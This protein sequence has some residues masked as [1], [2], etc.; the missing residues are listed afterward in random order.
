MNCKSDTQTHPHMEIRRPLLAGDLGV[1]CYFEESED[2]WCCSW[3]ASAWNA[4]PHSPR[5]PSVFVLGFLVFPFST[6]FLVSL[7]YLFSLF[8]LYFLVFAATRAISLKC[9]CPCSPCCPI[10]PYFLVC[11][12]LNLFVISF[13][14]VVICVC[15][16]FF[17]VV[18][19]VVDCWFPLLYS[20]PSRSLFSRISFVPP[21]SSNSP[22]GCP[23]FPAPCFSVVSETSL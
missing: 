18:G 17:L 7:F 15:L 23:C 19:S 22:S 9:V 8:S 11:I 6:C 16:L 3:G 12:T 5:F 14:S 1:L 21:F 20:T 10:F 4:F 2:C 13:V